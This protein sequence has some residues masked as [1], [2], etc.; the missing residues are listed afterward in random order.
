[1]HQ[2]IRHRRR[3]PDASDKT[4]VVEQVEEKIAD[5]ARAVKDQ[6][7]A[8]AEPV[9]QQA[10]SFAEQQKEG[11]AGRIDEM[12]EAVHNA[13][14]EIGK[15]IPLAGSYIHSGADQLQ[16]ASRLLRQNSVDELLQMTN[17][18]AQ[19][20]PLAFIGGSVAAGFALARFLKSSNSGTGASQS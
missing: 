2:A 1:M 20:R 19:E 8:A 5:A 4:G 14:D 12:A 6:A 10:R 13:A 16:R 7:A 18:L 11:G 3:T 9:T 15:Q 17:R